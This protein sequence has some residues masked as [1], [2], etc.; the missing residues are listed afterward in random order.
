M[1]SKREWVEA[2]RQVRELGLPRHPTTEKHWDSLAMV[3]CVLETMPRTARIL[4]A[5]GGLYS[6]ILPWLFLYGY[7]TLTA[8]NLSFTKAVRRGPIRYEPG[9]ITKLA[10]P[11]ASFDVVICQSVLEHG[12]DVSAFLGEASRVLRPG[13]LLL[14]SVDY[15]DRPIDVTAIRVIDPNYSVFN[16]GSIGALTETARGMGLT[17][18]GP[19]DLECH[20][21]AV[22]RNAFGLA[23]TFLMLAFA[24]A[25]VE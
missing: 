7:R 1:K 14:V 5:G 25:P 19:V 23:Y 15:S 10:F 17:V 16:R 9:D 20:E 12:V 8:V 22:R 21:P 2:T 11:D 3:A 24:K 13:G 6:V 18:T 4:D